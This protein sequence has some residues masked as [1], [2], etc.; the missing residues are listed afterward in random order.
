M[1]TEVEQI[2]CLLK[3]LDLL[4]VQLVSIKRSPHLARLTALEIGKMHRQLDN[5]EERLRQAANRLGLDT[6]AP[7]PVL[8]RELRAVSDSERL[9]AIS[10]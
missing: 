6:R 4:E 1:Q 5:A 10:R 8:R 9:L 3:N 2:R 7:M